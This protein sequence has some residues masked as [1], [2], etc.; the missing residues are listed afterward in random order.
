MVSIIL[1]A[2]DVF[3]PD[4]IIIYG[5]L[6]LLLFVIFAESGLF[7]GFF[8]PGDSLL[9]VAGLLSESHLR[10]PVWSVIFL[11]II[12]AF[13]GTVT[14]YV[15]GRWAK[16]YLQN[17]KENFFYKKKY[18]DI[19]RSFYHRHG[20]MA[21]VLGRFLPII[22]TFVPILAG[23]ADFKF[24]KFLFYNFI[25]VCIWVIFM[26]MAGYWLGNLFPDTI[27]YLEIIVIGL[28]VI[29]AVPVILTWR[30]NKELIDELK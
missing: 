22:R 23:I 29:T 11:L 6:T 17:K 2:V 19:T 12:S 15:F 7:F 14:G 13:L 9:F 16:N 4:S 25:G 18:L 20:A 30:R 27:N 26:V 24:T 21:F 3:K 1:L 28:I 5:G 10:M 8:L